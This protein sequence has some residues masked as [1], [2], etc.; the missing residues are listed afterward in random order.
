MRRRN[1]GEMFEVVFLLDERDMTL[2]E[3]C[4]SM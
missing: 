4:R 2:A 3:M 1:E